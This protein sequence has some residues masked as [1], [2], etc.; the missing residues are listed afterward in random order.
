MPVNKVAPRRGA[1][2]ASIVEVA[3]S[4]ARENGIQLVSL[5]ALA[6]EVGM[7]QPSLYVYFDSKHALYDA[8]FAD[9]NRQ[10][11]ARLD[12]LD[13]PGDPRAAVKVFIRTFVD[14]AVE[15]RERYALLLQRPIPGF[16]PT[17]SSYE[18]AQEVLSL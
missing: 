11:L 7:R 1:K 3:W 12:A 17:P 14:F 8:M 15:D 5:H 13:L 10:L 18:Y 9:G 6:K 2:I 4:L 16:E